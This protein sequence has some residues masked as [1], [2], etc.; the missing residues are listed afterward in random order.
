MQLSDETYIKQTIDHLSTVVR[1]IKEDMKYAGKL[2]AEIREF[3]KEK[4]GGTTTMS[5]QTNYDHMSPYN[6]DGDIP[7]EEMRLRAAIM[8]G[9]LD[10]PRECVLTW[11]DDE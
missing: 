5:W 6:F 11:S 4:E 9:E 8:D 1:S 2:F 10:D 7:E 3:K